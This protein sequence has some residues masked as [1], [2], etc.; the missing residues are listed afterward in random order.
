M[1][2]WSPASYEGTVMVTPAAIAAA[3]A[4]LIRSAL[5]SGIGKEPASSFRTLT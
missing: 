1:V 2:F 3:L 4:V 5:V